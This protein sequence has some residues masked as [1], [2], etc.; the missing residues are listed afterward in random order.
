[1]RRPARIRLAAGLA[2][3]PVIGL[4]APAA[5][6]TSATAAA[7]S[8]QLSV[9]LNGF[10]ADLAA[11]INKARRAHGLRPLTVVA[12]ATDVARRWSWRLADS[13]VLSHN[14]SIIGDITHAGSSAWTEIAENVGEGP[15][16]SPGGLFQAYMDSP[17]HRAN[18]LDP[19]A[20]Y[21][22]VGTVERDGT[23]WNTLDFTNAYN[24]AYGLTK[25]PADGVTMDQQTI[26]STTDVA[27]LNSPDQR[28]AASHHGGIAA[29]RLAFTGAQSHNGS[30]YTWLHQT[31]RST[32]RAGVMMRAAL[33]LSHAT[34]LCLQLSAKAVNGATVPITVSLHRSFGSSVKLGTV[35]VGGRA[36]WV[37][38]TLPAAAQS[39]RNVLTLHVGGN[40]VHQAG[41]KLR[42]AVY[43]V[44]AEV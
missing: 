39:F 21:L 20:H 23:A 28:F 13:Q 15:S 33:D 3:A 35:R 27:L 37:D 31:G 40:A 18:I 4:A 5:L 9:R 2:A 34:K 16:D 25:V 22:G 1:M 19:A 43:D 12:G 6:T 17:P 10:E 8:H 29:S 26:S 32:G 14:P 42:L 44:R 38:L 36:Q 30:A 11:D 41:G 24:D 7:G